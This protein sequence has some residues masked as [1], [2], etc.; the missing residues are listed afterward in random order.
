MNWAQWGLLSVMTL[1][2]ANA[3]PQRAN[4]LN[5]QGLDAMA[6]GDFEA[7][8]KNFDEALHIYLGLGPAFEPHA[9]VEIMNLGDEASAE[10]RWLDAEPLFA[11]AVER[12]RHSL[13]PRHLYTVTMVNRLANVHVLRGEFDQAE[14]LY[15]ANL[16]VERELYPRDLQTGHTLSGL[17]FV[18]S[19]QGKPRQALTEAE[20]GLALT[21]QAAGESD[22]EAGTAYANV[23][24]IHRIAGEDDRAV[25]LLR[26]AHAIFERAYGADS[27]RLAN[28][29]SQEGLEQM[30]EGNLALAND[31]MVRAVKMLSASPAGNVNLAVASQN[32]GLLRFRQ[33]K[34][35]EADRLFAEAL[36]IEEQYE[37][38]P[39]KDMAQT[40]NLLSLVRQKERRFQDAESLKARAETLTSYR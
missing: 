15:M 17:G 11:Q 10:G 23:A 5:Q 28:V 14:A 6:R 21:L 7:A 40:L 13:G 34:Y 20:E 35:A 1:W 36:K 12:A 18:H 30:Y 32:L 26:K 22:P 24:Q 39:G 38:R 27:A 29:L 8:R 16:A 9:A 4:D 25:P 2:G 31:N 37:A 33:K 19:R 3:Q